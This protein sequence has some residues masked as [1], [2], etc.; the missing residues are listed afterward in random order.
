[1]SNLRFS[2]IPCSLSTLTV[3]PFFQALPRVH[4]SFLA[5]ISALYKITKIEITRGYSFFF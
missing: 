3:S 1:M 2:F 4:L 5:Q